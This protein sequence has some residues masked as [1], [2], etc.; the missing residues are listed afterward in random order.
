MADPLDM[1]ERG[2]RFRLS[3]GALLIDELEDVVDQIIDRLQKA[4][5][6]IEALRYPPK[7]KAK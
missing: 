6:Q 2:T 3:D 4:E 7:P 1:T 5:T